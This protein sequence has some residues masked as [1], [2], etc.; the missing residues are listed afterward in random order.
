MNRYRTGN[1][2]FL[3]HQNLIGIMHHLYDNA[4]IS[5]IEL[6]R[7]TELNKTTVSSL[8]EELLE[9][10]FVLETGIGKRSG[11]GRNSV[12]LDLNPHHGYIVSSEIG[13][14]F[15]HVIGTDFSGEILWTY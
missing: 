4:P 13:G 10:G 12:L 8:I 3:R 15:V 5:R 9:N 11:A 1:Y 14:N 6:S 2:N 7:L